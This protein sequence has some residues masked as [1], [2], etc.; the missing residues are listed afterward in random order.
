MCFLISPLA[1][2]DGHVA[3]VMAQ[4]HSPPNV[5]RLSHGPVWRG[6]N[7]V[8]ALDLFWRAH[9]CHLSRFASLQ[10]HECSTS[11]PPTCSAIK[12]P[13]SFQKGWMMETVLSCFCSGPLCPMFWLQWKTLI[14]KCPV[15]TGLRC[16][17]GH[18]TV[19][20]QTQGFCWV[21]YYCVLHSANTL[22]SNIWPTTRSCTVQYSANQAS[23]SSY[24]MKNMQCSCLGHKN[25]W[26]YLENITANCLYHVSSLNIMHAFLSFINPMIYVHF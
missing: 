12:S 25:L 13:E 2:Q 26:I 16:S 8:Y 5:L 10:M 17:E 20:D 18:V 9:A 11:T 15:T 14:F 1:R 7:P 22:W 24:P 3:M 21:R 23:A 4:Y 19:T 6:G